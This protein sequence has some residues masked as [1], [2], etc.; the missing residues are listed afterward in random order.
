V[1][2]QVKKA[3]K[4]QGISKEDYQKISAEVLKQKDKAAE[5]ASSV[6]G[7]V[8]GQVER[9][10]LDKLAFQWALKLRKLEPTRRNEVVRNLMRYVHFDDLL[11]Q[12]DLFDEA[13]SIMQEL[14]DEAK[15]R[16]A[17]APIDPSITS[18][19]Q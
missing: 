4:A 19:I 7:Y 18:L 9:Y 5:Y 14:I 12:A 8:K 3:E 6:G 1:A 10:D 13:F 15:Q 16:P 11:A 17:R 2:K